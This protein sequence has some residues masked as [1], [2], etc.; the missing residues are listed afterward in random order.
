MKVGLPKSGTGGRLGSWNTRPRLKRSHQ[1]S[2][3]G[4]T[5]FGFGGPVCHGRSGDGPNMGCV[6]NAARVGECLW[7]C[8]AAS[9]G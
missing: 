2:P 5:G 3:L 4:W 9:R 1:E 8:S 7:S 6:P